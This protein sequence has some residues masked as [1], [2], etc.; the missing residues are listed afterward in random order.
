MPSSLLLSCSFYNLSEIDIMLSLFRG[1]PVKISCDIP[2]KT[3]E[4][5]KVVIKG[6]NSVS[7]RPDTWNG[8]LRIVDPLYEEE[9]RQ[10]EYNTRH[11]SGYIK[12]KQ[13]TH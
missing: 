3:P 13:E 8:M 7:G 5:V 9:E 6:I 4:D 10:Y 11:R 1:V 2:G 12:D